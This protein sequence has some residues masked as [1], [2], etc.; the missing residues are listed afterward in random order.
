MAQL[1]S[2]E[3]IKREKR[4]NGAKVKGGDFMEGF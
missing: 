4:A 2:A 3:G 1:T